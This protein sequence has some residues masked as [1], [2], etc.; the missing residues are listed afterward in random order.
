MNPNQQNKT[1]RTGENNDEQGINTDHEKK[2]GHT[3]AKGV[4]MEDEIHTKDIENEKAV[5]EESDPFRPRKSICRS[6]TDERTKEMDTKSPRTY[7]TGTS[8]PGTQLN[9]DA[10]CHNEVQEIIISDEDASNSQSRTKDTD[11]NDSKM[12]NLE[13]EGNITIQ[14]KL[15]MKMIKQIRDAKSATKA[16]YEYAMTTKNVKGLLKEK[17]NSAIKYLENLHKEVE[18]IIRNN[19]QSGARQG[20]ET[21]G[22]NKAR[23]SKKEA[24]TQTTREDRPNLGYKPRP[25]ESHTEKRTPKRKVVSP[26]QNIGKIYKVTE[27][28]ES[29]N[30][31]HPTINVTRNQG[32]GINDDKINNTIANND[33]EPVTDEVAWET[34]SREKMEHNPTNKYNGKNNSEGGP[35][36][37]NLLTNKQRGEALSI[38]TGSNMT[39]AEVVCKL[40]NKTG[41]DPQG[42]KGLRR[43]QNG[44]LL[45]E[46]NKGTDSM[47]MYKNLI[48]DMDE[49]CTIKRMVPKT[50]VEILDIDPTV[51][52]EELKDTLHKS[53]NIDTLDIRTK[54][55]RT[56]SVGLKR[57][58]VEIPAKAIINLEGK[59]KIKIG[60]TM[61]RI[62]MITKIT[63]CFKCHELG[64]IAISCPLK[65]E[66]GT[67]C[68][69]CGETGHMIGD[70]KDTPKCILC[71]RRGYTEDIGHVAGSY[72]C[73]VYGEAVRAKESKTKSGNG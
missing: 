1:S 68:R 64:H 4:E 21:Q 19:E 35:K 23:G 2:D 27:K 14:G 37:I 66:V 13:S 67:V 18:N 34:A 59:P 10:T 20:K 47:E 53:L 52:T 61:C 12:I 11:A 49:G 6:P 17:S 51:E 56:T 57:A 36:H 46:F 65:G 54:M 33:T 41:A 22:N 72:R 60:W 43:T 40:K 58:I 63:R 8:T 3:E 55:F 7:E 48:R 15:L 16:I 38:T 62:R 9:Q 73:P 45:I 39:F 69:K 24:Y 31:T 44:N 29:G 25:N 30:N 5:T 50:D 28:Q 42:V 32:S 70:C 26:L 71:S